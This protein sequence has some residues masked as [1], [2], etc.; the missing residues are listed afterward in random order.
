M[1]SK[2]PS[3]LLPS[4]SARNHRLRYTHQYH[5]A[6]RQMQR[7]QRVQRPRCLRCQRRQPR[8]RGQKRVQNP[9]LGQKNRSRMQNRWWHQPRPGLIPTAN[10]SILRDGSTL[11][12]PQ[13]C[14]YEPP[15]FLTHRPRCSTPRRSSR[16]FL[17]SFTLFCGVSPQ[18]PQGSAAPLT[19]YRRRDHRFSKQTALSLEEIEH[20]FFWQL[21]KSYPRNRA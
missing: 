1:Y 14:R 2:V 20:G 4:L 16:F 10:A 12:A 15:L 21:R 6:I 19:P 18:T 17:W 5:H 9:R 3:S 7:N 11:S 13:A 8:L